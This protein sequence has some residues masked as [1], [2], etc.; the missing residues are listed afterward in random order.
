MRVYA[1]EPRTASNPEARTP[2]LEGPKYTFKPYN[3]KYHLLEMCLGFTRVP[4]NLGTKG[5]RFGIG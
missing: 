4:S 2:K 3:P 5:S 1:Q